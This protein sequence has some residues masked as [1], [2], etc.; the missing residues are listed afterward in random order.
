[1]RWTDRL[2]IEMTECKRLGI[3]VLG[4]DINE[5][6]A[7]FATVGKDNKIRFG[8]AAIKNVGK[9]LT[10]DV[11]ADR[12]NNGPFTSICDFARRINS[13]KFNKKSWEAAI[14]TGAFDR[15]GDRSDLLFNLEKIQAYGSKIQKEA[16]SGQTDL[17]G[18]LGDAGAVPEVAI[19]PAPTKVNDKDQLLWERELMGLYLSAHPLDKYEKYLADY[20]TP[21]SE[22][23]PDRDKKTVTV[24]GII[25]A[26]RT[27]I[28]KSGSKMAF[29]KLEDKSSELEIIVFPAIY[30]QVGG[31]LLQD[32][33]VKVTGRIN[34]K[35][36]NGNTSDAK[37][38]ADTLE[39]ITDEEL[40]NPTT[41]VTTSP[42][43]SVIARSEATKQSP[44]PPT[45]KLYILL[46][47][48]D[49]TTSLTA[50][51]SACEEHPGPSEVILVLTD[52][53]TKRAMRM[54]FRCD[55]TDPL[56]SAVVGIFGEDSVTVK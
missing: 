47:N 55:L 21:F 28:T 53:G 19:A 26:V 23:T 54:P 3:E 1:M 50:F 7:D 42:N 12:D 2:A 46:K 40:A 8:L 44:P 36:Q 51:K 35:D 33:I 27:I 17:F 9:G 30:E 22:V 13:T 34:A 14:K 48:P 18:A 24:G 56:V 20:T 45:K 32:N 37:I 39:P 38:I 11:I 43:G 10:E 25:T 29:V 49:D 41:P 31:K 52:T 4:P 6:Y 15:F 16:A 5:S